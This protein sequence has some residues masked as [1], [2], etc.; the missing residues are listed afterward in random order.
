MGGSEWVVLWR[1]L[2]ELVEL[3]QVLQ[4][5]HGA[6]LACLEL[7][8]SNRCAVYTEASYYTTLLEEG[9]LGSWADRSLKTYLFWMVRPAGW[10][11]KLGAAARRRPSWK[12]R[13][14]AI[15]PIA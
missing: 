7:R 5:W 2:W 8:C 14:E 9:I 12:T 1:V 15:V 6:C 3:L 4:H 10:I 13:W 11:L